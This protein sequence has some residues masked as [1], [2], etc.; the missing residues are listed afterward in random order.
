MVIDPDGMYDQALMDKWTA[1]D[2][3]D[4]GFDE[5]TI[6]KRLESNGGEECNGS[7]GPGNNESVDYIS[8][9]KASNASNIP[10][11]KGN[12]EPAKNEDEKPSMEASNGGGD[13]SNASGQGGVQQAGMEGGE[14]LIGPGLILLGQ[15]IKAL[16]PIGALG[17]KPGSS[18]ASYTLSKAIPQT[19]TKTLGKEVG[20]EVATRVGTNVIGRALGRFVPYVGWGLTLYDVYDNRAA[21]GQFIYDWSHMEWPNGAPN[22]VKMDDGSIMYVCFL[23]GTQLLTKEGLKSIEKIIIGDSV[24]SYNL[25]KSV[26]E[27]S[28]VA[29]SFERYTQEIY[30]VITDNQKILVT[31]EHPFY[32]EEKGWVRVKNLQPG[33]VLKTKDNTKEHITSVTLKETPETVY[34]IEV[35]GNH[36]YFVTN[37]NI[38]V[39]N[40]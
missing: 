1:E 22:A 35:E 8:P 3:R 4:Q 32:V 2:M 27:L 38:L 5:Y 10:S 29:K 18:I 28:K 6:S 20:T 23:A 25:E 7:S 15:P 19:F 11:L 40:K 12:L 33:F 16:K 14:H 34:N 30:E 36:N 21:I 39:H 9:N 13:T 24:Y 17:S 26:V 31:A 37:S